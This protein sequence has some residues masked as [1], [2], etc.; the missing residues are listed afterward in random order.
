MAP[1]ASVVAI[2]EIIGR[3]EQGVTRP[4]ICRGEDD[5]VYFVKGRGAGR[6]SL[7]C[8]WIAGCFAKGFGLPIAPFAIVDVP[9]LLIDLGSRDDLMEL[10]PGLA[11]GS[12]RMQLTELTVANIIEV[13][14]ASQID[15]LVFDWWV[16][17]GDRNLSSHGGNPNLFWDMVCDTLVVLDHNQAFD[18]AFSPESFT[19]LHCFSAFCRKIR[20]D[21][22]VQGSLEARLR[23]LVADFDAICDTVPHEWWFVDDEQTIEVDFDRDEIKQMLVACTGPAFWNFL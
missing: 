8:E 22:V 2:C 23:A 12:Q 5:Q 14:E 1:E 7:I 18:Q 19:E 11:F 9:Q 3:S 16:R 20:Q 4:F 17:N 21:W 15:V 6:R 13:P 10:G